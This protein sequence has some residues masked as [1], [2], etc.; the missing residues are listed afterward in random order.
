MSL[1][2]LLD[3]ARDPSDIEVYREGA[4]T[5]VE[6][7][8][9]S[10][11]SRG[12]ASMDLAAIFTVL[13]LEQKQFYRQ[14]V[15]SYPDLMAKAQFTRRRTPPEFYEYLYYMAVDKGLFQ[16]DPLIDLETQGEAYRMWRDDIDPKN[17][18]GVISLR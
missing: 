16:Y 1:R 2:M 15:E 6:S 17:P 9:A 11:L 5:S 3:L 12:G 4:R 13:L 8:V 10:S 14:A 7:A 18:Y